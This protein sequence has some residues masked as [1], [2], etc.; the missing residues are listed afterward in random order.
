MSE[1][2]QERIT[3]YWS[4]YAAVYDAS[5]VERQERP[6]AHDVWA[7]VWSAALPAT[8][9]DV[10]DFGTGSGNVAL[11]LA[12][13]GY[14]VTGV[15]LAE[16]MLAEARRKGEA[17]PNAPLFVTADAVNPPFAAGSL[18]ALTARYVL[19]TLRDPSVALRNWFELLRPGGVLVAVDSLWYPGGVRA[20]HDHVGATDRDR[21]FR[22]A[23]DDRALRFLP[24][25][26]AT[27][28]RRTADLLEAAGFTGVEIAELPEVMELDRCYG[29]APGHRVRMQYRISARR[30]LAS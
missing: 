22:L 6:G 13:L 26:E 16:G 14:R 21:E 9:A 10:L 5:Q 4:A 15:D 28:I 1:A 3:A 27:D 8:T 7:R 11:L 25:A 19:W 20:A 2:A 29:V 12:K 24:L 17:V 18:D 30:P 23:Y